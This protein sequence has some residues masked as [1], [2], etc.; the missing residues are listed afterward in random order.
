MPTIISVLDNLK[1]ANIKVSLI[2]VGLIANDTVVNEIPVLQLWKIHFRKIPKII[3]KMLFSYKV[4][5]KY[6]GNLFRIHFF[7]NSY[8]LSNEHELDTCTCFLFS[9]TRVKWEL[10][11][12][13]TYSNVT[14]WGTNVRRHQNNVSWYIGYLSY[15][16]CCIMDKNVF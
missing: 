15:D 16:T 12:Y 4:R 9:L 11:L 13:W 10:L 8:Q 1:G 2:T 14:H 7:Q 3:F 5:S 6:E